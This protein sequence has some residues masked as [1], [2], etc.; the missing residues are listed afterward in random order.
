MTKIHAEI[1]KEKSNDLSPIEKIIL[2]LS[3]N[4]FCNP[5]DELHRNAA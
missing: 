3:Q 1:Q 4:S 5:C 2:C